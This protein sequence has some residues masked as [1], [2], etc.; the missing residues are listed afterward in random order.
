MKKL[1]NISAITVFGGQAR[2]SFT[3][4]YLPKNVT[5]DIRDTSFWYRKE[6]GLLV[7]YVAVEFNSDVYVEV[8]IDEKEVRFESF[9][10]GTTNTKTF[11]SGGRKAEAEF[12]ALRQRGFV[13]YGYDWLQ[14]IRIRE[15]NKQKPRKSKMRYEHNCTSVWGIYTSVSEWVMVKKTDLRRCKLVSVDVSADTRSSQETYSIEDGV[16]L[17]MF[18]RTTSAKEVAVKV[19]AYKNGNPMSG[20]WLVGRNHRI[21]WTDG[22]GVY[23]AEEYAKGADK[24]MSLYNKYLE[25]G[26]VV[27]TPSLFEEKA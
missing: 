1:F 14:K 27:L 3:E 9:R 17:V 6:A 23:D 4:L 16:D 8:T 12:R 26:W 11:P 15:K 22:I 20:S 5:V 10:N 13:E 19:V 7:D 25:E 21:D 2:T 18:G 24:L